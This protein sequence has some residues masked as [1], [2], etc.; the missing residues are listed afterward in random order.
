MKIL[1][2]GAKGQLGSELQR[3]LRDHQLLLLDKDS[4]DIIDRQ[5]VIEYIIRNKPEVIIHAAAFT[6]VDGCE[7]NRNI[8]QKVN[9]IGTRNVAEASLEISAKLIFISTDYVFDGKKKS[10]YQE[11]DQARPI[12][13]Y[14]E[15]K[16]QAEHEARK[17]KKHFILRT[18]WLYSTFGKNFPKTILK[19]AK[20][21]PCLEIVDDQIGS[22]TY[23]RDLAGLIKHLLSCSHYGT[24]HAVNSGQVS[25]YGLAKEILKLAGIKT[26]IKPI[27]S[28]ALGRPA[29]RPR[30]SVLSNRKIKKICQL[31]PW[32]AALREFF[33]ERC[34]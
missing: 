16:L 11:R 15:T 28:A 32:Q 17:V 1:I 33:E 31:R 24:Y 26:P 29:P 7:L 23:T 14:G 2:T 19:A 22:P 3:V 12:N 25:W 27:K 13:F 21:K 6:D 8:C 5:A 20:E 4:L 18:A 9:V 34:P 30:F 10:P